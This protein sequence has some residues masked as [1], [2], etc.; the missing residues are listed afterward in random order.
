ML[1]NDLKVPFN[2]DIFVHSGQVSTPV[3]RFLEGQSFITKLGWHGA[4]N[5]RELSRLFAFLK[6]NPKLLPN[7][8]VLEGPLH[9]LQ[10]LIP[11]RPI[12]SI[13]L[14]QWHEEQS[15]IENL[16]NSVKHT[17]VPLTHLGFVDDVPVGTGWITVVEGLRETPALSTL[18]N[19]GVV[20]LFRE[21]YIDDYELKINEAFPGSIPVDFLRFEALEKFEFTHNTGV[22]HAP[23][24][25][26]TH[27]WLALHELQHLSSW[28]EL[29]PSLHTVVLWGTIISL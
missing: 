25:S 14:L 19:I 6:G 9:I 1:L 26:D 4:M 15:P 21:K 20:K 22:R 16:M 17:M 5:A 8:K 29:S 23:S 27:T 18:K 13:T 7:L 3:L 11:I 12:S 28:R 10:A 24:P 2:L